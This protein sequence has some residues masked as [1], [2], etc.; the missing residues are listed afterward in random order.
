MQKLH[1]MIDPRLAGV[2]IAVAMTLLET[3]LVIASLSI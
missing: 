3:G 2:A 1:A